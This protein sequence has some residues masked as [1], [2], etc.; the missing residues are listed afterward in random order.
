[1]K[2]YQASGDK[3]KVMGYT[4]A[5][6]NIKS[7]DKPITEASEMGKIPFVGDAIKKKVKELIEQGEISKLKTLKDDPKLVSLEILA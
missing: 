3:G 6:S 7:Y 2:I 4:R 5:I 1:M